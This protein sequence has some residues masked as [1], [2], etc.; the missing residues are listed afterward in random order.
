M[1]TEQCF[2]DAPLWTFISPAKRRNKP[3]VRAGLLVDTPRQT[4]PVAGL[5]KLAQILALGTVNF[6]AEKTTEF[7][8][9]RAKQ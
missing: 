3:D 9:V 5:A 7:N 4:V 2:F 1:A 8:A 6:I